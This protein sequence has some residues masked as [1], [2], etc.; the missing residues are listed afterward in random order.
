LRK[1]SSLLESTSF[2]QNSPLFQQG[3]IR[4]NKKTKNEDIDA[5]YGFIPKHGKI[6]NTAP[7]EEA[8]P[9][10]WT[11]FQMAVAGGAGDYLMSGEIDDSKQQATEELQHETDDIIEWWEGFGFPGE[12]QG[13]GRLAQEERSATSSR[14]RHDLR[15]R[16][17]A[18]HAQQR[19]ANWPLQGIAELP[20]NERFKFKNAV[21]V[22]LEDTSVAKPEQGYESDYSLPDSPME[23]ITQE[24]I[25][26]KGSV[27]PMGSNL[28]HDLPDFLKW[29]VKNTEGLVLP[30]RHK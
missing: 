25:Q 24:A 4:L 23:E 14:R 5:A 16:A 7:K 6:G 29:G 17:L 13:I 9:L 26:R 28:D 20:S 18:E 8:A 11:A 10:D 1:T 21:H 27:V 12:A 2:S 15:M 22:E 19:P 30:L 3:S